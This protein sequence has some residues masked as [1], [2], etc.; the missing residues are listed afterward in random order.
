MASFPNVDRFMPK[1]PRQ[2]AQ[3]HLSP[4]ELLRWIASGGRE[5]P[6]VAGLPPEA[7]FVN[8]SYDFASHTLV[9]TIEHESF[10]A[11]PP[12]ELLPVLPYS[13]RLVACDEE[14]E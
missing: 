5:R 1:G 14:D 10:P 2:M 4:H 9:V 7:T 6:I 3:V 8:L 11:T 12:G 13:V